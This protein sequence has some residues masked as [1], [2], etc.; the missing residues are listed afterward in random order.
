MGREV[1]CSI[2]RG[3]QTFSAKVLLEGEAILV[4]GPNRFVLALDQIASVQVMGDR[5]GVITA[6]K[7]GISFAL[8]AREAALWFRKIT[9]P[10]TRLD[11]LGIRAGTR[12]TVID[13]SDPAFMDELN[14]VNAVPSDLAVSDIVLVS[15][16]KAADLGRIAVTAAGMR[17]S[18]DLWVIRRRGKIGA[19]PEAD[20]MAAGKA[21]G[22]SLSKTMRF[23]DSE[24]A[25]RFT[26]PKIKHPRA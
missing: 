2:T 13:V 10:S 1:V 20:V 26:W 3:D 9:A 22:L 4:R 18:A 25:E 8:G 23:S 12:V 15:V 6:D 19:V 11:K 5:L 17:R 16:I 21:L 24:T 7:Q 14:Q